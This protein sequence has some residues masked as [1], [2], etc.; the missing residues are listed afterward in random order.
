LVGQTE[1]EP[2]LQDL[3]AQYQSIF[4]AEYSHTESAIL[5]TVCPCSMPGSCIANIDAERFLK[6]LLACTNGVFSMS[7]EMPG[8]V[9]SSS[10]LA[11]VKWTE[12]HCVEILTSQRSAIESRKIEV[13]QSVKSCFELADMEVEQSGSYPGWAPKMDSELLTLCAD[14]YEKL[15]HQK[16][17]VRAIHAGLEC[18]LFLDKYPY[19]DMISFGPTIYGVHSPDERI[20]IPTVE[21]FWIHLSDVLQEIAKR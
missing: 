20:L 1:L 19:L 16:P 15:F 6:S 4:T 14:S 2:M 18:G 10:N 3:S 11:A 12:N 7:F 9:E 21:K 13:A 5:L 17:V 8:L